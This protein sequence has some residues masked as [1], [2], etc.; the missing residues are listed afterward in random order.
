MEANAAA[1]LSGTPKEGRA[2]AGIT[3]SLPTRATSKTNLLAQRQRES[4]IELRMTLQEILMSHEHKLSPSATVSRLALLRHWIESLVSVGTK[5]MCI[6]V[7]LGVMGGVIT[8]SLNGQ[9][10]STASPPTLPAV[11]QSEVDQ[12]KPSSHNSTAGETAEDPAQHAAR[13]SLSTPPPAETERVTPTKR[14]RC[15]LSP[16]PSPPRTP[17]MSPTASPSPERKLSRK[18]R[19]SRRSKK[20]DASA[21][22]TT[23][24][25]G[26]VNSCG[27]S[28]GASVDG[29][30]SGGG[31]GGGNGGPSAVVSGT[32]N[33]RA[34]VLSRLLRQ[35]PGSTPPSQRRS[36]L[37]DGSKPQQRLIVMKTA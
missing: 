9:Q 12:V 22:D 8:T 26:D 35:L 34:S 14:R 36:T 1:T 21:K 19:H 32:S 6:V 15:M 5:G 28:R 4:L 29:D 18:A 13:S 25:G 30:N 37:G 24:G 20:S 10:Q 23:D 2:N 31:G 17:S 27:D 16:A 7:V 3:N 11:Q 33:K